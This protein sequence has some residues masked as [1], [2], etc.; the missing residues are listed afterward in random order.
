M[1]RPVAFLTAVAVVGC[2]GADAGQQNHDAGSADSIA[3]ID[4]D[5]G[6]DAL[7][8]VDAG[9]CGGDST[10]DLPGVS[11]AFG[12]A[13]CSFSQAE[14]AAGVRIPYD[15]VIAQDLTGVHPV[16]NDEGNCGQPDGSGL[17]V[18]FD[19]AGVG[20][21]YCLC[22]IGLCVGQTITTSPRRGSYPAVIEWDGTNWR[23][24]SDVPSPKG[25]AFPP[26]VY[27]ITLVAEGTRD[28]AA[29]AGGVSSF[30]VTA[31]RTITITPDP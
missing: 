15:V 20:Q 3:I 25:P 4:P 21:H 16:P 18:S 5:A 28:D 8:S 26:D 23:G 11:L 31:T 17:I 1:M 13:R 6:I 9:G 10:S 14:I 12:A 7:V 2:G 24:P 27:M 19:I 22:D 29:G 30:R